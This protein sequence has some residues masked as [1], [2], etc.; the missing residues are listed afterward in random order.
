MASLQELWNQ[1]QALSNDP[2]E[3]FKRSASQYYAPYRPSDFLFEQGYVSPEY[4][5]NKQI[6]MD[7]TQYINQW[8][9]P[10]AQGTSDPN[11]GMTLYQRPTWE[12]AGSQGLWSNPALQYDPLRTEQPYYDPL[13]G[14]DQALAAG[15]GYGAANEGGGGLRGVLNENVDWA[16]PAALAVMGGYVAGGAAGLYGAEA[17][18]VGGEAGA[19]GLGEGVGANAYFAGAP[20]AAPA[21]GEFSLATGSAGA[22]LGGGSA[23]LGLTTP[24]PFTTP[25]VETG[26]GGGAAGGSY[27]LAGGTTGLGILGNAPSTVGAGAGAGGAGSVVA[28]TALSRIIDGTATNSDWISVLGTAGATGLGMYSAGQQANSLE[29]LAE[30]AR[31][32]RAPFLSK[33]NEWLAN[34]QAYAEGP[35]QAAMKG[36]LAGLSAK[37]GNPIGSG[38][39]LQYAT[40]AGLRDWRDAVTGMGNLGLAGQDLR[41]NLGV[42]AAARTG[43]IYTTLGGGVSRIANPPRSLADLLRDYRSS[44]LI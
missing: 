5:A 13:F 28:G 30:Q 39:A 16:V 35:G 23:G 40:D 18:A 34:P 12:Q 32:E 25:L 9:A 4:Y 14:A 41:A 44:G 29:R 3:M 8:M 37:F 31:V 27:G 17:G 26:L 7:P 1:W 24:A 10:G 20:A 15:V 21:A 42:G 11:F 38:A 19:A 2:D 22:G 33:A 6:A 36:T 43:D